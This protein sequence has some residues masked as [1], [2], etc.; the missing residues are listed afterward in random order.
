[1]K[2]GARLNIK[3]D[4]AIGFALVLLLHFLGLYGLWSYQIIP[5]PEEVLVVFAHFVNPPATA[6][7]AEPVA[8]KPAKL[9]KPEKPAKPA[10][11]RKET[12]RQV[13]PVAEHLLVSRAPVTSPAEPEAPPPPVVLAPPAPVSVS[14]PGAAVREGMPGSPPKDGSGPQP[15]HLTG[16]LSLSCS[17]RTPPVYPRLSVR[18][19]EQGTTILLVELDELGRIVSVSIKKKSGFSRLDEAAIAAVKTW[20]CTP[21][22]RNGAAVHAV[23]LQ[24][25]NFTLKGP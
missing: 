21:A 9:A 15:V 4:K 2:L 25:F 18:R 8:L 3:R 6:K 14:L 13:S 11:I 7:R 22:K 24:P 1:M 23:A 10:P 5:P 16:D 20:R 19:D 12:P 17:E